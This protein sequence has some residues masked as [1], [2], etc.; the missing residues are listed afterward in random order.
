VEAD[1]SHAAALLHHPAEQALLRRVLDLP[2]VVADAAARRETHEITR[3]LLESAQLFSAFY[4][5]CRVLSE[6]PD[7]RRLSEARL[8]LT[9]ATRQVLANGLGLLGIRAPTSM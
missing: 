6:D 9:D 2:D 5:D 8:A 7:E 1:D 3:F 4:R